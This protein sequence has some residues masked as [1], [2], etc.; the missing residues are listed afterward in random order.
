MTSGAALP[1]FDPVLGLLRIFVLAGVLFVA[2]AASAA[3]PAI[4]DLTGDYIRYFHATENLPVAERVARFKA[5][6]ATR[7]PGF[8]DAARVGA[9]AAEYD[10]YIARSFERF[11]AIEAKFTARAAAV[12]GQLADAQADF[13]RTFPDSTAMPPIYLLHSLN[14]MD[15]GTRELGG[16]TVLVFGADVIARTH[17]DDANERPFFEHELFHVY[18]APR[19]GACK[20]LWCALWEEGLATYVAARLNPGATDDELLLPAAD[21]ARIKA[22]QAAAVC[23]IRSLALSEQEDGYRKLFNGGSNLPG[24]P[25]RA[26]YFVGYLVAERLGERRTLAELAAWPVAT[27]RAKV[28]A[29]LAAMAP[30]CPKVP[31]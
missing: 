18:H 4:I 21:M 24:L 8:Y 28:R 26:G 25:E 7:I 15:G 10:S 12:A 5:L 29:T 19:F 14:E 11:P 2:G 6:M 17:R 16:R 22:G 13:A 9:P 1:S 3:P 23:A 31:D 20:P 27:A 30:D